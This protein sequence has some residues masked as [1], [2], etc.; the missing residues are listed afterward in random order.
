MSQHST[1][2]LL[3]REL[4]DLIYDHF[5]G[6]K[7]YIHCP[8]TR[9][10]TQK[11]DHQPVEL[12][13]TLTCHQLA[14]EVRD[15][16][17]RNSTN[18]VTFPSIYTADLRTAAGKWGEI[19]G[20]LCHVE[21]QMLLLARGCLS[22]AIVEHVTTWFPQ[23]RR[24]LD[25]LMR[26][27]SVEGFFM[28]CVWGEAPSLQAQFELY[29]LRCMTSH[30]NFSADASSAVT[31]HW[32]RIGEPKRV[33]ALEHT[34]W[35][36]PSKEEMDAICR[37]LQIQDYATLSIPPWPRGK[38][39]YSAAAGTIQFLDSVTPTVLQR[40]R[41]I[42]IVEDHLSVAHP[43]CHGQ[44]LIEICQTNPNLRIERRVNLWRCIL[45]TG[46]WAH[47]AIAIELNLNSES[48]L[49]RLGHLT[50]SHVANCIASWIVEAVA[51]RDLG[52]PEGCFTMVIDGNPSAEQSS[53]IFQVVE[54]RALQQHLK[55]LK[56]RTSTRIE[57]R[58]SKDHLYEGFPT[59]MD[60]IIRGRSVVK[61][62]FE[63][64][65]LWPRLG[66]RY[67]DWDNADLIERAL[68]AY[69]LPDQFHLTAPLPTW[70]ELMF[71]NH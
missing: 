7:G 23:F 54:H 45:Q 20:I 19:F 46:V 50:A 62:D 67:E 61:C 9:K 37:A 64:G 68:E 24:L 14:A 56:D 65:N 12:A 16:A 60:D 36:M 17:F 43:M 69:S 13:L 22:P 11:P 21:A 25:D 51:L 39:R 34:P 66:S 52:M 28:S 27:A 29:T 5:I 1:L 53:P 2:L 71:E 18:N 8:T 42:V 48:M 41:K 44:G 55:D 59:M 26:G 31:S 40:L 4:R 6:T 3:P 38:Y 49:W 33:V 63:I 57:R 15:Y 70:R 35:A 47:E 32:T 30:P 10:F 58:L